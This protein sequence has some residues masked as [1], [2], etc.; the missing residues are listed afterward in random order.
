[1]ITSQCF[2]QNLGERP[3]Y[4]E[5]AGTGSYLAGASRIF[6]DHRM[7][8]PH[9]RV[10]SPDRLMRGL[11]QLMAFEYDQPDQFG[12]QQQL[13]RLAASNATATREPPLQSRATIAITVMAP[14]A[15][16]I[17]RLRR[18]WSRGCTST[19]ISLPSK[20]ERSNCLSR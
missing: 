7:N 9:E 12:E 2:A 4:F 15:I 3:I 18:A 6:R 10:R 14:A 1:M 19:L 16:A 13:G 17:S 8:L 20:L 5:S 11:E